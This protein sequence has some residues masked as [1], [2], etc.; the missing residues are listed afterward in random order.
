MFVGVGFGWGADK[1]EGK[2]VSVS[3]CGLFSSFLL[4]GSWRVANGTNVRSNYTIETRN[5]AIALENSMLQFSSRF[6]PPPFWVLVQTSPTVEPP[7]RTS[8]SCVIIGAGHFSPTS[9]RI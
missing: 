1:K 8:K 7:S 5:R 9:K 2:A 3:R 4:R 6:D